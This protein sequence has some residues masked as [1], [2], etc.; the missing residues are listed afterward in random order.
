MSVKS[1]E[2]RT[3]LMGTLINEIGNKY[4]R[5][6]VMER[7]GIGRGKLATWLCICDCGNE[8]IVV[9]DDLRRGHTK[10]CGC[11]QEDFYRS[12]RLTEGESSFNAIFYNTK[13]NAERRNLEW[14]L[15]KEEVKELSKQPCFYCGTMPKQARRK[16]LWRFYGIYEYNGID[17]IDNLVGYIPQNVVSCC[18][19]CNRAKTSMTISEFKQ[20]I[21]SVYDNWVSK[22]LGDGT[23]FRINLSEMSDEDLVKYRQ[24]AINGQ[25]F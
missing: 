6:V 8:C 22:S 14:K 1:D 24:M 3:I 7:V 11:L 9:G 13:H 5:L 4:S 21:L 23:E 17:R 25:E 18:G 16:N 19:Q 20:W 2:G 10:S 15:T 12:S